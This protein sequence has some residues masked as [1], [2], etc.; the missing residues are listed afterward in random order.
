MSARALRLLGADCAVCGKPAT[1]E[2]HI[3]YGR[4][5]GARLD[6]A[7]NRMALCG[8]GTTGCHGAYHLGV[9]AARV[10]I[11]R[12]LEQRPD[13]VAFVKL[14]LGDEAGADYLRRRYQYE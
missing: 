8:S 5:Y 1:N 7:A 2:H 9:Y 13:V 12:A 10:G 11:G 4:Q 3:L 6:V 14:R